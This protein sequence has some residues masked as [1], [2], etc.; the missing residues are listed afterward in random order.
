MA[1]ISSNNI[2]SSAIT[3][4]N[5]D[6]SVTDIANSTNNIS[7][8]A[9]VLTAAAFNAVNVNSTLLPPLITNVQITDSSYNVLDDVAANTTGGYIQITGS[10]FNSGVIVLVGS[11]S[12]TSTTLVNS[13]V[14]RAQ[15]SAA[16][17]SS[18]PVYVVNTNGATAIKVN[19]L[20]Y[21]S[22]PAWNTS[23]TLAN[24]AANT[25]F[26]VNLSA[27]SD[28]NITY[29][30]T[31]ALP[32]GTSLLANGYFYGTVTIGVQ[33]TYTFT[34]DAKDAENQDALRT[35]SLTVTIN[36]SAGL[37]VWGKNLS[38]ALG[39]NN[40]G[41][42]FSSPVQLN[43][44]SWNQIYTDKV[45]VD[46]S[47]FAIKGN[48]SLWTWGRNDYGQLGL[49]D[50]VYRSSPTQVGAATDWSLI[51]NSFGTVFAVK[52]NGT[53]WSWGRNDSGQLGVSNII[54]RSSPVQVG[55]LTNW[56]KI[57]NNTQTAI[58]IKTDGTLWA[59]GRNNIGQL[60]IPDKVYRSS[61]VQVGA[62]T[63]WSSIGV[64]GGFCA[65]ALKTDGTLWAWGEPNYG[66]LGTNDVLNRSSP[67][68]VGAA[69]D[70]SQLSFGQ[71]HTLL[72]K[73][74][75]TLWS[76]GQGPNGPIGLNDSVYRSSPTQIGSLTTW[77]KISAGYVSSL[78]IK[79][80]G[81]LWVWGYG[82][83]GAMGMNNTNNISSPTQV[84]TGTNW[85]LISAGQH[86]A[87]VAI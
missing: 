70:W 34:V 85:S 38:G 14:I 40:S 78:A 58:A 84:G 46:D 33:T 15:V 16:A 44:G 23:A 63:T 76:M 81:T 2:Q 61:P 3:L 51:S 17:A 48:A 66:S 26:S 22:F 41:I 21:S 87:A 7:I 29:S 80:D 42:N 77:S 11:N 55:A 74:N 72:L 53:L 31:T 69:T 64:G 47:M 65:L 19:G 86:N 43:S 9:S 56:S 39:L 54:S 73:T 25:I 45:N 10:N 82:G 12:A 1:K 68:Q 57:S 60:G 59:W 67:T 35:F 30:N 79:T 8:T 6:T 24:T 50:T 83:Y 18:Y 28:S 49:N 75:G 52:T 71:S 20:T 62:L 13:S 5:L 36:P 27:N 32:A 37:Y 4:S